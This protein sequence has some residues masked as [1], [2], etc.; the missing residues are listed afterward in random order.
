MDGFWGD[1]NPFLVIPL[2]IAGI[3]ALIWQVAAWC[4]VRAFGYEDIDPPERKRIENCTLCTLKKNHSLHDV[5]TTLETSTSTPQST[6]TKRHSS[7]GVGTSWERPR[8]AKGRFVK[9][10]STQHNQSADAILRTQPTRPVVQF[11]RVKQ[12][13]Q[14]TR[15]AR[16]T[17]SE[18]VIHMAVAHDTGDEG[19]AVDLWKQYPSEIPESAFKKMEAARKGSQTWLGREIDDRLSSGFLEF[20]RRTYKQSRGDYILDLQEDQTR[21]APHKVNGRNVRS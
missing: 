10:S 20:L 11:S 12:P 16:R 7:N 14:H 19:S 21:Q 18:F 6:P 1:S 4:G 3:G 13:V 5:R 8:D 9:A 17:P 15:R 2:F